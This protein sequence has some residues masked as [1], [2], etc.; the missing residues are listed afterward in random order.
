MVGTSKTLTIQ[1]EAL[2][3]ELASLSEQYT[4]V[5]K[6]RS[7]A[8]DAR[9]RLLFKKQADDLLEQ[10]RQ[11]E[12]E[13][14]QL[15]DSEN[16][17]NQIYLDIQANLPEIDFRES[18]KVV[19]KITSQFGREGGAA[20]FLI[21]NSY[22]MAGELCISRIREQ[23]KR[24]TRSFRYLKIE[25]SS[26]GRYDELGLLECLARYF[27][28][29]SESTP[30]IGEY[31]Q[32]VIQQICQSL[33]VGSVVFIEINKWDYLSCQER[34][35]PWFIRDFWCQ[36]LEESR[37]I[38]HK[39]GLRRVNI[40]AVIDSESQLNKECEALPYYC[41]PD[42]FDSKKILKLPLNQWTEDD[43]LEWLERYGCLPASQIDVMAKQIY[44]KTMKG[45]PL[46]VCEALK[47]ELA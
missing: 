17:S 19:D 29:P 3:E 18:M 9:D 8:R 1:K 27:N 2:E 35:L 30:N 33:Q 42:E 23:L 22:S 15:E 5:M 7:Q 43:I 10:M 41:N 4:A 36:L 11:V 28:L 39:N 21:D 16:N 14:E 12:D 25:I 46:M 47:K 26:S 13:L 44:L 38:A 34:V 6:Q 31:S 20:L 37:L 24:Q 45:I 32:K 40:V